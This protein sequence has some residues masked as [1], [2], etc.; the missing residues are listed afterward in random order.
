MTWKEAQVE[1]EEG[2]LDEAPPFCQ[3]TRKTHPL[4]AFVYLSKSLENCS[5]H[6][7]ITTREEKAATAYFRSW[8]GFKLI[9]PGSEPCFQNV[10][11][12]DQV[13]L[14]NSG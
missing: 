7:R 9:I 5:A 13:P 2:E 14:Q 3:Q 8:G 10:V 12:T 1:R 11:P 6:S 4:S